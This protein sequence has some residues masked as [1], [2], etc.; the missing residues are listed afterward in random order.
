MTRGEQKPAWHRPIPALVL[1]FTPSSVFRAE[2]AAD[3]VHNLALGDRL[4]AADNTAVERVF[5]DFL[6][7][8]FDAE[9]MRCTTP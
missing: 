5:T 3:G 8:F 6:G 1:R 7:A 2:R 4:A 9:R